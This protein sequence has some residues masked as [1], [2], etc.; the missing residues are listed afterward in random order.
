[1]PPE[2]RRENF[3]RACRSEWRWL[4]LQSHLKS[5]AE[6]QLVRFPSTFSRLRRTVQATE[7]PAQSVRAF[8]SPLSPGS[9]VPI[10]RSETC[11]AKGNHVRTPYTTEL[12]SPETCPDCS[13]EMVFMGVLPILFGDGHEDV[14]YKCKN[15]GAETTRAI[16]ASWASWAA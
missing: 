2:L 1:M 13:A 10:P 12:N 9:P 15:C 8:N 11:R 16:K 14:T 5:R 7:T 3:C 6:R 4:A